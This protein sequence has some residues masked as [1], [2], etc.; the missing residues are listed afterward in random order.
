MT[1]LELV[2]TRVEIGENLPNLG[3]IFAYLYLVMT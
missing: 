3:A 2:G 1:E